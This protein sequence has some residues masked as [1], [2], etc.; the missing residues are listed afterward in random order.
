MV[1][2][3]K[4]SKPSPAAA[5]WFQEI[6]GTPGSAAAQRH[7]RHSVSLFDPEQMPPNKE[8]H[9]APTTIS[10]VSPYLILPYHIIFC[11]LPNSEF[12][13]GWRQHNML[14]LLI[15]PCSTAVRLYVMKSSPALHQSVALTPSASFCWCP[16]NSFPSLFSSCFKDHEKLLRRQQLGVLQLLHFKWI[17]LGFWLYY[18][19]INIT[20]I[21]AKKKEHN[22]GGLPPMCSILPA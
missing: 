22:V 4:F 19:I 8:M 18:K 13:W 16:A 10:Q 20:I 17:I 11:L 15:T 3:T 6:T 1:L 5:T 14:Q 12:L 7:H 21:K 2:G 9:P